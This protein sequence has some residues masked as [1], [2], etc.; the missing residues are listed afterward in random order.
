MTRTL[1]GLAAAAMTSAA[2]LAAAQS[3]PP[4]P[5]FTAEQLSA[6]PTTMW[7]TF[8]GNLANQ[9]FSP[10]DQINISNVSHVKAVWRTG[11]GGSGVTPRAGNQGEPLY[12]DGVLYVTTS[13]NDV[14]A[15]DVDSGKIIWSYHAELPVERRAACCGWASRG[16]GMGAG[17]IFV[18][19]QDAKLIALD[20]ATGNVVWEKQIADPA[21]RYSITSATRYFDGLVYTGT[22][23]GVLGTRGRV[24]AYDAETGDLVWRFWTI[25]GPGEFGHETW[26]QDSD[27]WKYGGAAVWQT[28]SVDRELGMIYFGTSNPGPVHQGAMRPGDNL[29]T[30]SIVALDAKT[31]EYRWHFQLVRHDIWDYDASN[32]TVLFDIE[33]DGVVR[34]GL[35]H[36]GKTGWVYL[37]D[38]TDGS[39]LIGIED[40]PVP[41]EPR[42]FT[43]P[44]QPFPIGDPIVPQHIDIAPEGYELINEGR[45]F[46]P[47]WDEPVLWKPFA[48]MNW[49]PSAYDPRTG[50]LYVCAID[51]F[52]GASRVDASYSVEPVDVYAG[53]TVERA[54][55]ARRGI[56]AAL[57]VTTNRIRWRQQWPDTCYSGSLATAGG[58]VF[59]GRNDG[60]VPALDSAT[61]RRLWSFQTDGGVNAPMVTF[62]HRGKQYLAVYAGGT[63][64]APTRKSDGVWLFSLDGTIDPLPPGSGDP[65]GQFSTA[66]SSASAGRPGA[67]STATPRPGRAPDPARGR[68]LYAQSCIVCHGETGQGG[69]MGGARLTS[70]LSEADIMTV[71]ANGRG[72]MPAFAS[73]YAVDDLHDLAAYIL[74]ELVR[75]D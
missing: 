54:A 66:G 50:L 52:W 22:S 7:A 18:G 44:T 42:Q 53:A 48:A 24:D 16:V 26:P 73:I 51:G 17:K 33:I 58:L 38:R 68:R 37:L 62:L 8:G 1:V 61:G 20:Q 25:P 75:S 15:I 12:Y 2:G 67:R 29:F 70:A 11:L 60:R 46:T 65:A 9:R 30:S 69:P 49:P 72:T 4:S 39:P 6:L 21:E 59:V 41:Q 23:G 74:G 57:D 27:V 56:Y 32:P 71:L 36:A 63:A 35:A 47:F 55:G 13:D 19:R 64:L 3:A 45:I 28:P 14:F 34:R 40:R 43:S 10:L 5:A 31:G